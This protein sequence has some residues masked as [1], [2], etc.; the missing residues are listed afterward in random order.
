MNADLTNELKMQIIQEALEV[1]NCT[2]VAKKHG[3]NSKT[4][5]RW[6][7]QIKNKDSIT[8][9]KKIRK[10]EKRLKDRELEIEVLKSLFKKT[11]PHWSSVEK[12]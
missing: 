7:L 2:L 8:E 3:M 11:Y 10:L 6:V 12:L 5:N 9:S 4:L 1:G